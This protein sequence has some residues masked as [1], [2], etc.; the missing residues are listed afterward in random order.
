MSSSG[1][2]EAE[3]PWKPQLSP[4]QVG[5]LIGTLATPLSMIEAGKSP[6]KHVLGIVTSDGAAKH[7]KTTWRDRRPL[8]ASLP[9][10]TH[11]LTHTHTHTCTNTYSYTAHPYT[12]I[13]RQKTRH[14]QTRTHIYRQMQTQADRGRKL[15]KVTVFK[16]Y[17]NSDLS[18]AVKFSKVT[19]R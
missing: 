10:H 6:C 13:H 19:L 14:R 11:T 12:R 16:F 4:W 15:T 2:T 3:A 7:F 8:L 5:S 1:T 17:Q 9:T 18:E